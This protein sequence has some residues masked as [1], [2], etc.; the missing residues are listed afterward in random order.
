MTKNDGRPS[1]KPG[2]SLDGDPN[3]HTTFDNDYIIEERLRSGSY[4]VVYTT[5]HR[6]TK[7][8]FAVKVIDR[9]KLKK[10][11][12][13]GV[14][15]EVGIL[16]DFR[17]V[18]HIVTLIDF[19]ETPQSF[20]IVQ[21]YAQGGDVFDRLA[22]RTSYTEKDARDLGVILLQTMQHLHE[23]KLCHRDMKPENLLL[24]NTLDDTSILVADF[25]FA[26]YVPD[27][28]LKTRCGTPAFVAPQ[29]MVG[30]RYTQQ[31]DMWS[32]G[33]L[34][35]MLIGGYPPFQDDSHRGLF[36]KIRAAD[37]TFHE[38]Y[39][40]NVS[41]HAKQLISKLLTVDP[42]F[43]LNAKQSLQTAWLEVQNTAD[44][45]VR[46]L[47]ISIG[48][49]KKFNARKT[50][51][52]AMT[53]VLWSV[54]TAFRHDKVSDLTQATD[55]WDEE[56]SEKAT[57]S[58]ETA[59]SL[60]KAHKS[61]FAD[62]YELGDKIHRGSFA[63]V[64]EC[65]H[66]E[67]NQKYAVKIIKREADGSTDE[68]VLHE[69]AIMNHLD[70]PNIVNVVDFFEEPDNYYIVME[71]MSGGD[72]F[73]RIV[74]MTQYTEKDARDLAKILLEAVSYMHANGVAHRDL[75]PQNLLLKVRT[76]LVTLEEKFNML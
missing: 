33:C 65:F 38:V 43:R 13:E 40:K 35:F 49:L 74:E 75:K 27:E 51:K 18:D 68:A 9:S 37:F 58:H 22:K 15:R 44:L 23:R 66:R 32:V 57:A 69:V 60:S 10:K 8:L 59:F 56:T 14:Y 30:N 67:W 41:L 34:L 63:V 11:D 28:G 55:Q 19:Y 39:W 16:K 62:V 2:A 12:D 46:D 64:K 71:L 54:G 17:D 53:A 26:A 3:T 45:S 24:R 6:V 5:S 76:R 73:D 70:H 20:H 25:G 50:L 72:V 31:V 47:S 4:G 61:K 48:E 1:N 52:S 29:I 7:E 36:R 42:F 21:V